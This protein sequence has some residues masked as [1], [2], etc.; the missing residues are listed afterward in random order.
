MR[1]DLEG[2]W[3]VYQAKLLDPL[4]LDQ[5]VE[6]FDTTVS[7]LLATQ[8]LQSLS[9]VTLQKQHARARVSL[10]SIIRNGAALHTHL[11]Y[12]FVLVILA[13][14]WSGHILGS[15]GSARRCDVHRWKRKDTRSH[16]S[17]PGS[18]GYRLE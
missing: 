7:N 11:T 16:A 4:D 15:E 9:K 13:R 12:L 1:H 10:T 3:I 17:C 2:L 5:W 8:P 6:I 14:F 18:S